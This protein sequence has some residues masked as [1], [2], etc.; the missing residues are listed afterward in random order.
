MYVDM[1]RSVNT[2]YD[3]F[4]ISVSIGNPIILHRLPIIG[5]AFGGLKGIGV[6]SKSQPN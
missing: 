2:L 6:T 1:V 5:M 4:S 3:E